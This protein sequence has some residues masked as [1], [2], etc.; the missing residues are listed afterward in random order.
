MNKF[1]RTLGLSLFLSILFTNN[2][3]AE[4]VCETLEL[5]EKKQVVPDR[6]AKGLLWKLTH[7]GLKPSYLFG[8]MHVSDKEVT[9][10]AR[11][12]LDALDNAL[13]VTLE[14]KFD[15][16]T[17]YDMS[18]A[19]NYFDGTTLEEKVG[20]EIYD[21]TLTL[22]KRY[23][24][25]EEKA[26]TLKPWAAYLSIS[27]PPSQGGLPLD[28]VI[29]NRG[30]RFGAQIYGLET[31]E[32]QLGIFEKMGA[33]EQKKL[34]KD[35]VCNYELLQNDIE[36]MKQLYLNHDLAGLAYMPE[37]YKSSE[38]DEY[39]EL[40]DDLVVKRNYKMAERMILRLVEGNAFIAV[41][42]LHLP[43]EEGILGL[44]EKEGFIVTPIF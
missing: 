32:E 36:E 28:M 37:K 10:L 17:F 1:I 44:L 6:H 5:A 41:G 30:K 35:T 14:V 22:L 43:G 25:S 20:K 2:V 8:T 11:P 34:L 23:G 12:V 3:A 26:K 33:A 39:K 4:L 9:T 13:S 42:A 24:F 7:I 15:V 29:L 38:Q 19:M 31:L 18:K 27:M 21:S 40:M 16:N